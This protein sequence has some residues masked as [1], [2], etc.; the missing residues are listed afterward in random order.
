L[1]RGAGRERGMT[2]GLSR[3]DILGFMDA[4]PQPQAQP[5]AQP[6]AQPA[7]APSR[8][9]RIHGIVLGPFGRCVICQR[10]EPNESEDAGG[11]RKALALLLLLVTALGGVLVYE[12]FVGAHEAPVVVSAAPRLPPPSTAPEVEDGVSLTDERAAAH[13]KAVTE[14][15]QRGFDAAMRKVSVSVYTTR[16]CGLCG[17]A[18]EWMKSKGYVFTDIDAEATSE[19]LA[20]LRKVNPETTVPTFVVDGEVFVGF[21]PGILQGAMFRAADKRAR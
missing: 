18:R 1:K 5:Y 15:R 14:E 7:Q 4:T 17:A 10:A 6:P 19:N 11:G 8:T 13:L 12:G 3:G 9:C 21:G 2:P 16:W 20:A